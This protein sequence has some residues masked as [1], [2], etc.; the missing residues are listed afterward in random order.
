MTDWWDLHQKQTAGHWW[1]TK[2]Y[3]DW[4]NTGPHEKPDW[5]IKNYP[6]TLA[7]W[8]QFSLWWLTNK[9]EKYKDLK[10]GI[11]EDDIRWNWYTSYDINRNQAKSPVVI[12]HY[13]NMAPKDDELYMV[14]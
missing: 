2:E 6:R 7:R 9:D 10:V 5:D 12:M 8:D 1:P 13:S 11:F 4:R 14:E 3:A